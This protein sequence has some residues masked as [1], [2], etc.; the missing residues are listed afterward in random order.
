MARTRI[1]C[2]LILLSL[3]VSVSARSLPLIRESTPQ[4]S[5]SNEVYTT[6]SKVALEDETIWNT[7]KEIIQEIKNDQNTTN[8]NVNRNEIILNNLRPGQGVS[9]YKIELTREG[10][11]VKGKA[12]IDV[13]LSDQ[14][15]R[16][17]I[18]FHIMG[19]DIENV[20]VAL[21]TAENPQDAEKRDDGSILEIR[22]MQGF[23]T[24]NI[25]IIDYNVPLRNDGTGIFLG[26][27]DD[28]NEYIA[29]NLH[30]TNAKRV[31]PCMDEPNLSARY[32]SF[33]F[34]DMDN[35]A[36]LLTNS[37]LVDGSTTT[38]ETLEGPV[39]RWAMVAHSLN[40]VN[41]P[42]TDLVNL[43]AREGTNRQ[44]AIASGAISHFY[45]AL[46]EWTGK[47]HRNIINGQNGGLHVMAMPDVARDWYGLSTLCIWEPY[48]L[49]EN[50]NAVKQRKTALVTIAEGMARQWFGWALFPQNWRDQ[51]VT[52]GL[53]S[54]AAYEVAK[55]FQTPPEDH[56]DNSLIDMNAIFTT[57]VI[58]E[59]LYYD[60]YA[61]ATALRLNDP[62]FEENQ[63]RQHT[64]G[65][66]RTKAP[67]LLRMTR[68]VLSEE[69]DLVQTT[70]QGLLERRIISAVTTGNLYESLANGY[71][72]DAGSGLIFS[73]EG[74]LRPWVENEGYPVITVLLQ[75][76]GVYL[77]QQRFGFSE[78]RNLEY[79]I[80]LTFTTSSDPNFD[81]IFPTQM[82]T[83]NLLL[84][85]ELGDDWIIFNLQGQ[86]YY[87][88]NY[89][90]TW[91]RLIEALSDPETREEIHPLNR[92]TLLDDA[93]NLARAGKI[94]YD[95]ALQIAL[96]MELET[97][98]AVWKAFV[99]NMDFIRKRLVP[100][101]EGDERD[102][103]IYLRMIRRTIVA[104]EQEIGF[105]PEAAEPAMVS[106][107]RGLVMEHACKVGYEPCTAA[108]VDIFYDPTSNEGDINPNI[109]P[110]IRPAVYCTMMREDE[111]NEVREALESHLEQLESRYERLVI[112][113]SLACSDDGGFIL[114]LLAQTI[115]D[116]SSYNFV[117][118]ERLKVFAAVAS[119]SFQN[120]VLAL[121]FLIVNT[122]EIREM[123][124]GPDKLEE[125]IFI[126]AEN[127]VDAG[128][129]NQFNNWV[130]S[131]NELSR[132][133]DSIE[134]ARRAR[135]R[136][137][138]NLAWI[139]DNLED[140]YDWI[141]END[142]TTVFASTL[143]L[144]IS[145]CIALFNQ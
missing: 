116:S 129:K 3:V 50:N 108:A 5:I 74:F 42:V 90:D 27:W 139:D 77:T 21:M 11:N 59:S 145:M 124:G 67:A 9:S 97:E 82:M 62:I 23:A 115:S 127:I 18:K 130:N 31:F 111:D 81:D 34:E 44:E 61:S 92:A 87:R 2:L 112:L 37:R 53:A 6:P 29:M 80:P 65:L 32:F 14:T 144:C 91:D 41:T 132:L 85:L 99:R 96:T 63:I 58:Q 118:E 113:E 49:M 13:S 88:V 7:S 83:S 28:D 54:Y 72:S 107:T 100:F 120:S 45:N 64:L 137:N 123:Y 39:H 131:Q 126:M 138:E 122:Q 16:E 117:L 47:E 134:V 86:G 136:L 128:E 104:V 20:Q 46:N 133:D 25:V 17:P 103:D 75:R 93:L 70:A 106:L 76:G 15:L 19:L 52:A 57:D 125:A 48:I 26:T 4:I 55:D 10:D 79:A 68:L 38:F 142:A 135:H 1:K 33:T 8:R 69:T 22:L 109:P 140:V 71:S 98:Y 30:P 51:W 43:Y 73:V 36:R 95:T 105:E 94:G 40:H 60:A 101:V 102:D 66:L 110:E 89:E 24:T 143:L 56:E 121:N 78:R 12:I 141:H 119:S 84:D 114:T 35:F